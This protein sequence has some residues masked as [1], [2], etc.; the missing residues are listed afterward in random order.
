MGIIQRNIH[1][2]Y[3]KPEQDYQTLYLVLARETVKLMFPLL[4]S[5]SS[6]LCLDPSTVASVLYSQ[7]IGRIS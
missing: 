1:K 6:L 2:L 3:L 7:F 5:S 4:R